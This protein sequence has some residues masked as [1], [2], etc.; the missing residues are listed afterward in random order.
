MP[1]NYVIFRLWST[2]SIW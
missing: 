1:L 2:S